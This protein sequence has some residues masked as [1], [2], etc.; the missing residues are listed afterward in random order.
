MERIVL[1]GSERTDGCFTAAFFQTQHASFFQTQR[2]SFFQTQYA[3]F[4]ARCGG[5]TAVG[6][7]NG[8]RK[9]FTS[10]AHERYNNS[11]ATSLCLLLQESAYIMDLDFEIF[12]SEKLV[13]E[14]VK[15]PAL[16]NC[17]FH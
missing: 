8:T 2:A 6:V 4:S 15:R 3:S 14:V 10:C 7:C 11:T 1:K 9:N 5:R 13:T 17:L 12:D 16:Y